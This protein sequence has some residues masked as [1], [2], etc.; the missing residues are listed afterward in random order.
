[1]MV[2]DETLA[3]KYKL[4]ESFLF[5]RETKIDSKNVWLFA[6]NNKELK[7]ESF[8]KSKVLFTNKIN[9]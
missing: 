7:F 6:I 8:N 2:F 5:M 4:D 1:M 3:N 9:F